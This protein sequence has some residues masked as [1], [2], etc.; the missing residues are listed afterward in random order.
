MCSLVPTL[1]VENSLRHIEL[2]VTVVY[3]WALPSTCLWV[4]YD[5]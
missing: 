3:S 4:H 1:L 2:D 5:T